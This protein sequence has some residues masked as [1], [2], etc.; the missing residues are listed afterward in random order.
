MRNSD[1]YLPAIALGIAFVAKLPALWRGWRNPL[2]R[3]VCFLLFAAANCFFFAAPPTISTVNELTG[4][5]NFSGPLVYCVMCAFSC[6]CLVL[7]VNWRGGAQET[8]RRSS[9]KWI[10]GYAAAIIA[11][12][13]FFTLGD[14]PV[15][16]LRDLDTYYATTPFIREMIVT[17]LVAH[18][19]S[20][21]VTTTL[22]VRWARAVGDWLR[23]GLV[24]LVIGFVLNLLFGLAK[25]TAVIARWTGRDWDALSTT[26]APP[27]V[28]VGGLIVTAG[29]LLPLL[30][31]QISDVWHAWITYLRLGPLWRQ[32]RSNPGG[33]GPLPQISWWAGPDMRLT[34]RETGIH[35]ELLKLQP[36]LDNCVRQSAY[37]AAIDD[38]AS[39]DD[40]EVVG[41]AAMVVAAVEARSRTPEPGT[42][43][44][45][46]TEVEDRTLAGAV[47]LTAALGPGRERL[48]QLSRALHSPFV[49][50]ARKEAAT[51]TE[52][53][54]R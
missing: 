22:C 37:D 16:R 7:I 29:F 28:A 36:H 44:E 27:I 46:R 4:I 8:V 49:V 13:V 25:L 48:V 14:A 18:M 42:E 5:A 24:V 12:P 40:A 6:A 39:T 32:L 43:P 33:Q 2:V 21:V 54:S 31:P 10:A 17:Y 20:A 45:R 52:S 3:S 34:V 35:D 38:H 1:Y 26:L 30:G 53:G 15:E 19:V 11:L 50:A 51:C 9:R 47:A 23:V 41:A